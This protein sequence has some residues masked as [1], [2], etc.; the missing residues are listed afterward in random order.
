MKFIIPV[1]SLRIF[2]T[3]F[4]IGNYVRN[5][6]KYHGVAEEFNKLPGEELEKM[7]RDL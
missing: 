1:P 7:E 4:D 2:G 6:K 3:F 5:H